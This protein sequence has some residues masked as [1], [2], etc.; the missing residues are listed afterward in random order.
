[1]KKLEEI[2]RP[3]WCSYALEKRIHMRDIKVAYDTL[4]QNKE[5]QSWMD[6]WEKFCGL[7]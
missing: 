6:T 4:I 7:I 3:L 2:K 5:V 1:M